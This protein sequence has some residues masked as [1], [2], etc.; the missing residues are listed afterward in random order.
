[1]N[2]TEHE[3]ATGRQLSEAI[4]RFVA[5]FT[6]ALA[7]D[8]LKPSSPLRTALDAPSRQAGDRLAEAIGY[9]LNRQEA[10]Q[11][12]FEDGRIELDTGHLERSLRPVVIGRKNFLFFGSLQGGRTA[13]VLYS[14][15]QSA[16]L[17]RLNVTAYLTD[18]LRRLPALL[19][20]DAAAIGELLPDRW[21]QAQPEHILV[22]RLVE[23][24]AA[25]E[26]RRQRRATRRMLLQA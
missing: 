16:R 26:H 20:N 19:P 13:A 22:P 17:H 4:A 24:R 18:V 2:L 15:V 21:A 14:V 23:S 5:V 25:L 10:L 9:A 3:L 8:Q 7:R 6:E 12:F 11:R 1:M